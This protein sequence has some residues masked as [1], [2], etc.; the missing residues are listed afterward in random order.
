[1]RTKRIAI[2]IYLSSSIFNKQMK[3][4]NL[5]SLEKLEYEVYKNEVEINKPKILTLD[6][7]FKI[8]IAPKNN[9]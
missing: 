4:R 9:V 6:E 8:S 1:M 3:K 2:H 7:F 5:I